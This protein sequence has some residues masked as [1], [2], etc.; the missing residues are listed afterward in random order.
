MLSQQGLELL[1]HFPT[2]GIPSLWSP[3]DAPLPPSSLG[4]SSHF[5]I[6]QEPSGK[7][8]NL[9]ISTLSILRTGQ[10]ICINNFVL[11]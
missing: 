3:Q 2:S 9:V 6:G 8:K 11:M 5:V 4:V 1:S 7:C 10:A